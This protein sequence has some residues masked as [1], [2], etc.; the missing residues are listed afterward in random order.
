MSDK[1]VVERILAIRDPLRRAGVDSEVITRMTE[2]D[3]VREPIQ[4]L[5]HGM[6][7][8]PT[9]KHY[10]DDSIRALIPHGAPTQKA[11]RMD[12][13]E[14]L[15]NSQSIAEGTQLLVQNGTMNPAAYVAAY[16]DAARIGSSQIT[17]EVLSDV[18]E[19]RDIVC[20]LSLPGRKK[21]NWLQLR[22]NMDYLNWFRAVGLAEQVP[23]GRIHRDGYYLH[24]S[25]TQ[26]TPFAKHLGQIGAQ[27][28]VDL[29][30]KRRV[31][32]I[33]ASGG[34]DEGEMVLSGGVESVEMIEGSDYMVDALRRRK[35]LLPG[36]ARDRFIPPETG[37]DMFVALRER[38]EEIQQ[39]R[40]K[41][42]GLAYAHS[43]LH[44]FD[45]VELLRL[46]GMIRECMEDDGHFAFAIKSVDG[47][48]A[49]EGI[50]I[51]HDEDELSLTTLPADQGNSGRMVRGDMTLNPDG[52]TRD[53]RSQPSL[54]TLL[55]LAKFQV[56]YHNYFRLRDYDVHGQEDWINW[57]VCG[58]LNGNHHNTTGKAHA[59]H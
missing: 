13:A 36:K 30:R 29:L 2:I 6:R 34:A 18:R 12:N 26:A 41:K 35:E 50:P 3:E 8:Q 56:L 45:D 57:Y 38:L 11:K 5:F 1:P 47:I 42:V 25:A 39:G 16:I 27:M 52:Q 49:H 7:R 37:M 20:G 51:I 22:M 44:Y 31:L 17:N 48:F 53:F 33:G 32:T 55:R 24:T 10:L 28:G 43:A 15:R 40:K 58:K 23:Y 46:L 4:Q 59:I 21:R 9:I 14:K 19:G 54:D